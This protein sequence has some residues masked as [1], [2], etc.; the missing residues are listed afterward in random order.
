[1]AQGRV[2]DATNG[3]LDD[4]GAQGARHIVLDLSALATVSPSAARAVSDVLEHAVDLGHRVR[5]VSGTPERSEQLWRM[6]SSHGTAELCPVYDSREEA[7][8]LA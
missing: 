6:L 7:L 8:A 3:I 1:M 5:V 4:L 2:G